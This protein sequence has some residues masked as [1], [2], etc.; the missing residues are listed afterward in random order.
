[1]IFL[2]FTDKITEL[3]SPYLFLKYLL[4]NNNLTYFLNFNF[5]FVSL[6]TI[7]K[8][9]KISLLSGKAAIVVLDVCVLFDFPKVHPFS[10]RFP[11]SPGSGL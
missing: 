3:I 5:F 2:S 1:M 10:A 9:R 4:Y 11:P 6:P 7:F 8:L